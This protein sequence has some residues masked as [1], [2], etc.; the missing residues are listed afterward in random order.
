ML[1]PRFLAF[2]L[3][4]ILISPV[5]AGDP[6]RMLSYPP[7]KIM[8]FRGLDTR[9]TKPTIQDSR[10]SDLLNVQL[11]PALDIRQRFGFSV[12]NDT[13]DD[14]DIDSPAI[15]GIFDSLFSNGTS[16]TFAFLGDKVKYDN[17]GTWTE[18]GEFT[19]APILTAGKNNQWQCI[20]A[21][22]TAVCTND[23]DVVIKL[24]SVPAKAALDV[25][26]LTDALT[27]ARAHIWYRNFLIFGN[28]FEASTERPTRFRWSNVGTTET[29]TDTDFVDISTFAGDEIV[30]FEEIY[31]E[32]YI[33]LTRSI[34]TASLVGGDDVFIF[35]KVIDGI[36][37]VSTHA[38]Q[39]VNLSDNR[40]AVF[41]LTDKKRIRAFN[42]AAITDVGNI[43]QASLD[44]LNESRLENAVATCEL[45]CKYLISC[46][47]PNT[48]IPKSSIP[49]TRS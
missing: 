31:G 17:S 48:R 19:T 10:A 28:T 34:W 47:S 25:S 18:V 27:K 13:L 26:D 24:S 33:F 20:M 37:A 38:T 2:I 46:R 49:Y 36:G 45:S 41:F 1:L 39:V 22:D 30:A 8:G 44:G 6:G 5:W 29:W 42:G 14:L 32:L 16:R 7:Q 9:S 43:I 35:R 12:I 40:T 23:V 4:F 3:T 15:T 11:S 21:L